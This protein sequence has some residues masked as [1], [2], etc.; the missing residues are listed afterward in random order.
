MRGPHPAL[1]ATLSRRRERALSDNARVPRLRFIVVFLVLLA[2]FELTLL[3]DA[4][5]RAVIRPLTNS[6]AVVSGSVIGLTERNVRVNGT[7]I[8]S[9]CFAVDIHNGCNG[10][11]AT[12]FIVAAVLAFPATWKKRLI[13]VAI[14]A[15]IIQVANLLRVVTLFIIGC[16]RRAWFETFHLAVWQ[17]VIFALAVGFFIVWSRR[18]LLTNVPNSA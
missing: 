14:G 10:V 9:P 16:H 8:T 6:I 7:M 15:A 18:S 13:G 3:I 11:E 1:R 12:M 4:V 2:V 5:D 17:T